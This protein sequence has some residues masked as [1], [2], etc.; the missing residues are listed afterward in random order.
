MR[1]SE[2]GELIAAAHEKIE[3]AQVHVRNVPIVLKNS[4]E[5]AREQ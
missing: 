4:V 5:G 3:D 2:R 1:L